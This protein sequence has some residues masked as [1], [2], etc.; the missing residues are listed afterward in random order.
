MEPYSEF[1]PTDLDHAGAFLPERQDWL[2]LPVSQTRDSGSLTCSNFD[3]AVNRLS[4]IDPKGADHE[5][6]RFGHWGPGWF[7]IILAR[8]ETVA[9]EYGDEIEQALANYP[10]LDESDLGEREL[11]EACEAWEWTDR[12]ERI[13]ILTKHGLSIFMARRDEL[14]D[15]LPYWDDFYVPEG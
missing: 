15:D 2:V 6:Y 11:K 4:E 13:R 14:P 9:A 8:P 5:V 3:T 1:A 10:V 12:R 7:E